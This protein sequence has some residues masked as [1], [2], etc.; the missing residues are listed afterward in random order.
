MHQLHQYHHQQNLEELHQLG[1]QIIDLEALANHRGSAFGAVGM[2]PQPT[3]EQFQNL[4]IEGFLNQDISRRIYIEDESSHI[5]KVSLPDTL[6]RKMKASPIL[7]IS[8]PLEFRIERLVEEYGKND[9]EELKV[10]MK[11][12]ERKLGGQNMRAALKFLQE[13]DLASVARIMLYYYDKSYRILLDRNKDNIIGVIE[14]TDPEPIGIAR[15]ILDKMSEK[16]EFFQ[17]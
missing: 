12:I 4:I 8:V 17:N 7:Y 1:E 16:V 15:N 2:S 11:K 14:I 13:D 9:K 6:W 3:V 5:G 10:C